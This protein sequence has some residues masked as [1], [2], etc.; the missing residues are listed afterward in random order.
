LDS[1]EL[2][3]Y[4]VNI[5]D[6]RSLIVNSPQTTHG[7]LEAGEKA[8]ADI[9]ENLIRISAGLEDQADLINDLEQAFQ[10]AIG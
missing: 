8:N 6:A 2:F 5:G 9:P 1:V 3:H 4:H 7:E 10:K